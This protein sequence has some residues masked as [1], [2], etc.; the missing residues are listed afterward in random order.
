MTTLREQ[1]EL[2]KLRIEIRSVRNYATQLQ[3]RIPAKRPQVWVVN[4]LNDI[5]PG[6][7][8][9]GD[10]A[11]TTFD[12]RFYMFVD[13]IWIEWGNPVY[14]AATFD[15]LPVDVAPQA[16]GRTTLGV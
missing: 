6:L 9:D 12:M 3:A 8:L 15:D 7:V 10:I 11:K 5:D 1:N 2:E 16:F 4:T 14:V 13:E